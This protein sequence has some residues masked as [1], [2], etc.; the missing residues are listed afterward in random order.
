VTDARISRWISWERYTL[1]LRTCWFPVI[2][3]GYVIPLVG[4]LTFGGWLVAQGTISIGQ[5]TTALLR[6]Q[7]LVEPL[8]LVLMW[9]DELQVGQA[10]SRP[11]GVQVPTPRPASLS[12]VDDRL[13]VDPC[14]SATAPSAT[15]GITLDVAPANLALVGPSGAGKST[16]G[17]LLAGIYAPR[18]G[19]WKWA[20][21][22]CR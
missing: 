9:Y 1:W 16:L 22:R 18:T 13:V 2:E 5:L 4:V 21:R 10:R 8:D 20:E 6:T 17:R 11:V 15:H 3:A 12:P 7:M 14:A 19:R